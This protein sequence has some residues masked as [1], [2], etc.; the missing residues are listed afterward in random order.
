MKN[1]FLFVIFTICMVLLMFPEAVFAEGE[2]GGAPS[3]T[4]FAEKQQLMDAFSSDD[5]TY[6][7]KVVFGK[8]SEGAPLEWF[9]MGK[10]EG[11]EGDNTMIFATRPIARKVPYLE[12]L[13][14][15][16]EYD[17]GWGC[18]YATTTPSEV[19]PNHYGASD[20]RKLL[21]GIAG[22]K[23]YF[24]TAEQDIMNWTPIIT[25]DDYGSKTIHYTTKEKL[26]LLS[27]NDVGG[28]LDG[29]AFPEI[30]SPDGRKKIDAQTFIYNDNS[31]IWLRSPNEKL[32]ACVR[33]FYNK[34]CYYYPVNLKYDVRPAGNL[35]LSTVLFASSAEASAGG[36]DYGA[37]ESD[38]A[39][40]LRLDGSDKK[41]GTVRYNDIEGLIAAKKDP[42][43]S[44]PVS[45]VVQ[46]NNGSSDWYYTLQL[47]DSSEIYVTKGMLKVASG[48]DDLSLD[49]CKI[50]LETTDGSTG[51]TYA[52]KGT[53]ESPYNLKGRQIT[54]V[55]LTG[56]I[57][58]PGQTFPST[59]HMELPITD[60]N[61]VYTA[62]V[63]GVD[64]PVTG[65][66][67]WN[68]DYKATIKIGTF[69]MYSVVYYFDSSVYVKIDGEALP[70]RL[71]PDVDGVLTITKEFSTQKQKS[72]TG[73]ELPN[74]PSDGIFTDYYGYEGFEALPLSGSELGKQ[75][76]LNILDKSDNTEKKE[77]VDVQWTV[78]N[79]DGA[80]Y[81][82]THGAVNT[83]R[84]TIPA[85]ALS[86]Y[87]CADC[88]YYD[89]SSGIITGTVSITNKAASPVNITGTDSATA[90]TDSGIDV[91]KYFS[92]DSNSGTPTYTLVE[93]TEEESGEGTISGS[94][95]SVTKIG[96]FNIKLNT[97]ANG[98]YAAGEKT[99]TLTVSNGTIQYEASDSGG[100][101]DGKPHSIEVIV[102]SPSGAAVTYST[103]GVIYGN[104][105]P[106]FTDE[107][108]YTVYYRIQKNNFDLAEGSKTVTITKRPVIITADDQSIYWGTEIDREK[109][110]V[111]E[112]GLASGDQITEITLL[113]G[114]SNLTDSGTISVSGVKI[115]NLSGSDVTGNYDITLKNGKLKI[116]H[117]ANIAPQRIEAAKTKT[118]YMEGEKLNL[119]DIAV[120]AYYPDG[121]SEAVTAFTTNASDIDMFNAGTKTL[122]VTFSKNGKTL[123]DDIEIT[124]KD[125]HIDNNKDHV[126]EICF[127]TI[128]RHAG[129][130]ATCIEK[131]VCE[132]CGEEYGDIDSSNHNLKVISANEPTVTQTGNIMY[133]HCIDCGEYFSDQT[134]KNN[135]D[136]VDAILPKL[137]PEIIEGMGQKTVKGEPRALSFRSN[138]AFEDFLS[139]EIDGKT[140][141]AENYSAVEGS[142]LVSL[143]A[144]YVASLSAGEHTVGIVSDSG[145]ASTTF[146][147]TVKAESVDDGN[148]GT[149]G[150][151]DHSSTGETGSGANSLATGDNS[152]F[153]LWIA[154]LIVSAGALAAAVLMRRKNRTK[155]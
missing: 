117:D 85:D 98:I 44:D 102:S 93:G 49:E 16:I 153:A 139:V 105:N 141:D 124:V 63:N 51:M 6:I 27:Y 147:V 154:L 18:E 143:N 4:S 8:D 111:S 128:S 88:P 122:T 11:V 52:V 82:N 74:T 19:A 151:A 99:I 46:G 131:A 2:T 79:A 103:D 60:H 59:C 136:P 77:A 90:F 80:D 7:G 78:E 66:V 43:A 152:H 32:D 133:W 96:K 71:S 149:N 94:I 104:E 89:A 45:L 68:K 30:G 40:V 75:A 42:G 142:I 155:A 132:Y 72:I 1:R 76:T 123:T 100:K 12:N 26:Y 33:V 114:T 119:D 64:V 50:W 65:T 109:Y 3:V 83:F 120:K 125:E 62:K 21:M 81:D 110:S 17:S 86:D 118:E 10:D 130:E 5:T 15:S 144:D 116:A 39:M 127:K 25:I 95:L 70:E 29:W 101:Y 9:I 61:V 41:I 53:W 150:G 112:D 38:K 54:M 115:K 47:E 36:L 106:S 57:P 84:W 140:L 14:V 97:A 22:N 69:I 148:G 137:P 34:K 87:D 67:E 24:T 55:S 31:S 146:D 129:G 56:A 138:A 73:I 126:C 92:I 108:S 13:V 107:G 135:I 58:T 35:D 20:V 91:S 134:G 23:G 37:I 145:T 121:Y 48:M 113:P 28:Y